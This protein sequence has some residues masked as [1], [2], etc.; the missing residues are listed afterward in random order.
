MLMIKSSNREFQAFLT[1]L[2]T[3][4]TC[5]NTNKHTCKRQEER[6]PSRYLGARHPAEVGGET[7]ASTKVLLDMSGVP[8]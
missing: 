8:R 3:V 6:L 2:Y 1:S 5:R 7:A 4:Y